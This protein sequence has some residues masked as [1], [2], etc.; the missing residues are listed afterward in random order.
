MLETTDCLNQNT[1]LHSP[2]AWVLWTSLPQ[3]MQVITCSVAAPDVRTILQT[4]ISYQNSLQALSEPSKPEEAKQDSAKTS[5][6]LL[7]ANS[8]PQDIRV[9]PHAEE[10]KSAIKDTCE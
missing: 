8:P 3:E 1:K 7:G 9:Q 2:L 6:S 10:H 5:S 4:Y